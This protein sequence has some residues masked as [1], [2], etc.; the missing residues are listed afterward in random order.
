MFI[1]A[2]HILEAVK[3]KKKAWFCS[4]LLVG[5][6]LALSL[7]GCRSSDEGEGQGPASVDDPV[8]YFSLKVWSPG[9]YEQSLST[10]INDEDKDVARYA[11]D[12]RK[13]GEVDAAFF[14]ALTLALEESGLRAFDGAN[15]SGG[16]EY[17]TFRVTFASGASWSGNFMGQVPEAFYGAFDKLDAFFKEQL[18]EL[19]ALHTEVSVL[20]GADEALTAQAQRLV[21]GVVHLETLQIAGV[22]P[23]AGVA[24]RLGLS[25]DSDIAAGVACSP[26]MDTEPYL[27]SLVRLRAGTDAGG[28]TEN[29]AASLD[30]ERWVCVAP[31]FAWIGVKDDMVLCV[32]G[33]VDAAET[34]RAALAD[35][36]SEIL[37]VKR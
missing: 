20:D 12:E 3:M 11:V 7:L 26:N 1:S 16:S 9:D 28:V 13:E 27:L 34:A 36:W 23:G 8:V 2:Y 22:E 5:C 24:W 29:F 21:G 35:G 18:A 19:P 15:T 4:V 10:G 25:D 31:H 17:A 30:W 37:A 14:R 33:N 6:L 32:M